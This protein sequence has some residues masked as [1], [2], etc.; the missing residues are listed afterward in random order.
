MPDDVAESY[1][2]T[3]YY[4][5]PSY[6]SIYADPYKELYYRFARLPKPDHKPGT[7]NDKPV[8]VIVL[9]K[10]LRYVG[11]ERLPEGP[12]YDTFNA[13]VSPEGLNIHIYNSSDEDRLTF[14]TYNAKF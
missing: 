3:W 6:G 1:I 11:E 12:L 7:F 8:I 13:Y 14:Y 2:S 10:D 4:E 5:Q 9:D